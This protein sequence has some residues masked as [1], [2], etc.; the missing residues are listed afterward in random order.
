MP[1][2]PS[3]A[4][5]YPSQRVVVLRHGERR[6]SAPEAPA[7]SNPPLTE[8]GVAAVQ[9]TAARLKHY[10]GEDAA[11]N[12]VLVVSPFLRT[13]QTAEALQRH[14][15]GAAQA[16]VID[17]TLCEVFGPSRIKTSRAPQLAAP[18]ASLAIGGLPQ[19]GE[20]IETATERYVTNFLRNG[21]VYGGHLSANPITGTNADSVTTQE[22]SQ[23][24]QSLVV[25]AAVTNRAGN[26]LPPRNAAA[27]AALNRQASDSITASERAPRDV[28]LVTHG[29]AISAVVS[30]FYPAR[31]VYEADFLSFVIMRRYGPGNLVYHLDESAG[32]SWF[33][34]GIDREPED[35]I[36][37]AM[38][39]QRLV[40]TPGANSGS[41]G[42]ANGADEEDLDDEGD[43]IEFDVEDPD[44]DADGGQ[45][46]VS[47]AGS[48]L[49]PSR[50]AAVVNRQRVPPIAPGHAA[51][52]FAAA[53]RP[54]ISSVG[55]TAENS[56][57]SGRTPRPGSASMHG[58]TTPRQ[59]SGSTQ[60]PTT[61]RAGQHQRHGTGTQRHRP[62]HHP[63][64]ATAAAD[65]PRVVRDH[66]K[67][68]EGCERIRL[69]TGT[70]AQSSS[71][72]VDSVSHGHSAARG[73]ET[74][75]ASNSVGGYHSSGSQISCG[76]S[77]ST[78]LVPP[79]PPEQ[80]R[81]PAG[82]NG[83]IRGWDGEDESALVRK[84]LGLA[85]E[86]DQDSTQQRRTSG[87]G[88]LTDEASSASWGQS[89]PV[90]TSLRSPISTTRV[91][92][93]SPLQQQQQQRQ[94]CAEAR[95]DVPASYG[96][97]ATALEVPTPA[98]AGVFARGE[99]APVAFAR[100]TFSAAAAATPHRGGVSADSNDS[101]DQRIERQ[102]GIISATYVSYGMRAAAGLLIMVE[103]SVLHENWATM[104]FGLCA[105]AWEA[106]LS[107]TLY[108]SCRP[109]GCRARQVRCA[110][111]QLQVG[112]GWC[113]VDNATA[114]SGA[115]SAAAVMLS[116]GPRSRIVVHD[117]EDEPV[118]EA[119]ASA[120]SLHRF[121]EAEVAAH[122]ADEQAAPWR[123]GIAGE[124]PPPG[125]S[126][127]DRRV[128]LLEVFRYVR[129]VAA[130]AL[131][132][133][134]ISLAAFLLALL[135]G[136]AVRRAAAGVG[137][138]FEPGLG[139]SLLLLYAALCVARGVWDETKLDAALSRN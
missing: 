54:R 117:E 72:A 77:S 115:A 81:G 105:V 7:E 14:G 21:D 106:A 23:V 134:V 73:A 107:V 120:Q 129:L 122:A 11:R 33:V 135:C 2:S 74:D 6:D 66:P 94:P 114:A 113:L 111:E 38:E 5:P 127:A 35:T 85:G 91:R 16:M 25:P 60:G 133:A 88:A 4:F 136:S 109:D 116:S 27:R 118:A 49:R 31:V 40:A 55:G 75:T 19:W 104:W 70:P 57:G 48:R 43:S 96:C 36:L 82:S 124:A 37:F 8:A 24:P 3:G 95:V 128:L 13:L 28:I 130:M 79:L 10:L 32:V 102:R 62:L 101:L 61:P 69:P 84:H 89:K 12:A 20:S 67:A 18:A 1:A 26:R 138:I 29:D 103:V 76:T 132:L 63:V 123:A 121:A 42:Y 59:G 112:R 58:P 68:G 39:K 80:A 17:N 90:S 99:A 92:Q 52:P 9:G 100:G 98:A 56:G 97:A 30:H 110:L 41:S 78:P 93:P 108:L 83:A 87:Y 86:P 137:S 64:A 139:L 119:F 46:P 45:V 65:S 22:E 50:G 53:S 34:E 131:K 125:A 126:G 51:N 47:F 15:V 44:P 71:N